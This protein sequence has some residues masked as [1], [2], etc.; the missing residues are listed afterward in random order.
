M[1]A[2]YDGHLKQV[3]KILSGGCD[4]Y[5]SPEGCEG[6][7][8]L[9][10]SSAQGRL[11]IMELLISKGCNLDQA[12]EDGFTALHLSCVGGHRKVVELLISEGC[13]IDSRA[14]KGATPLF[15]ACENGNH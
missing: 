5:Q 4:I 1:R 13:N 10:L 12:D 15:I 14:N 6:F 11:D 3:K 2:C 8:A 9:H 7:T